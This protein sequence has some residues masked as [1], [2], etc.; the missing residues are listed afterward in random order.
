MKAYKAPR[1]VKNN[2]VKLISVSGMSALLTG[3]FSLGDDKIYYGTP[4]D[5]IMVGE[6]GGERYIF[7]SSLGADTIT[8]AASE[9]IFS[10]VD[11]SASNAAVMVYLDGTAG[12]GGHAEGD[13]LTHIDLIYGS[14][15]DDILV[16]NA[17]R[18]I[19]F[20]NG[21]NDKLIGGDGDDD[22]RGGAGADVLDGGL[23]RD[24]ASY[25]KSAAAV[26]VNLHTGIGSGGNAEGDRLISIEN[27]S[28][29][30]FAD[31]LTGNNEDN[32]IHGFGGNDQIYGL[33]GNDTL[34]GSY[35]NARIFG[36]N[37]NDVLRGGV[38]NDVL[39]GGS[40]D[41]K[42]YAE[43]DVSV[44]SNEVSGGVGLDTLY[45]S[46][47]DY[48]Y[49]GGELLETIVRKI[50]FNIQKDDHKIT[51]NHG[52]NVHVLSSIELIE[53]S[54][55]YESD[56]VG[57]IDVKDIWSDLAGVEQAKFI[58]E[59]DFLSWLGNDAGYNYEGL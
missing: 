47:N 6:G 43:T 18:N 23:G 28:G 37:G 45:E 17:A 41:D 36:G 57:H 14:A 13:K 59:A 53:L 58:G 22:F 34:D 29:S 21:G 48:K 15:F 26:T 32:D 35:G 2:G 20:G 30:G 50:E 38:G 56:V 40:G 52:Q 8:G 46:K 42:F 9:Y 31:H 10:S 16:G 5:D 39:D 54:V 49:D 25:L 55:R 12:E 51:F 4:G 33:D 27:V 7:H 3:C 1:R 11:Y 19:L 24:S 44:G